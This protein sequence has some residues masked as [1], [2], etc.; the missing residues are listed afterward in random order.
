MWETSVFDVGNVF[1]GKEMVVFLPDHGFFSTVRVNQMWDLESRL[2]RL[3]CQ[4]FVAS[5][6]VD[7]PGLTESWSSEAVN[8]FKVIL[9]TTFVIMLKSGC[10]WTYKKRRISSIVHVKVPVISFSRRPLSTRICWE[11]FL[12]FPETST[13]FLHC[14]WNSPRSTLP[15]LHLR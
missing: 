11:K 3:P 7:S 12:P 1:L 9:S 14:L 2:L 13:H 8:V 6:P 15:L 4:A 10:A 5:V